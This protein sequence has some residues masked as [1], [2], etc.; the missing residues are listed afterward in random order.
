MHTKPHEYRIVTNLDNLLTGVDFNHSSQ[1]YLSLKWTCNHFKMSRSQIMR[2]VWLKFYP[3]TLI[4]SSHMCQKSKL[5][6]DKIM[7]E[8]HEVTT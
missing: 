7:F 2:L 5:W 3:R 6:V 8:A 1:P 4:F